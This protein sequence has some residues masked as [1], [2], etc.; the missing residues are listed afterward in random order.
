MFKGP[1]GEEHC[2]EDIMDHDPEKM[3]M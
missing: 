2:L 1:M 3:E